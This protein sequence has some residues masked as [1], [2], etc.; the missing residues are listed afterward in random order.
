MPTY[1]GLYAWEFEKNGRELKVRVEGQLVFNNPRPV[2]T[3]ALSGLG[4]AYLPED[5]VR[6]HAPD[7]HLVRVLSD[8]WSTVP[9]ISSLLPEP[10][11]IVGGIRPAR[12]RTAGPSEFRPS[13]AFVRC[14]PMNSILFDVRFQ[15]ERMFI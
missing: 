11:P 14:R 15:A 6:A 13:S 10:P 3:A 9:W 4:I 2:L 1:G 7:K 12:R 8:W 5:I